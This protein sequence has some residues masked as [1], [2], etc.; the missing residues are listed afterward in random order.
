M[1]HK[2]LRITCLDSPTECLWPFVSYVS[3]VILNQHDLCTGV[4]SDLQPNFVLLLNFLSPIN[5]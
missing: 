5:N 2:T 1:K 4:Y 3:K